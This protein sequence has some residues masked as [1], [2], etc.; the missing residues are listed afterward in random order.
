MNIFDYAMQIEK[1]AEGFADKTSNEGF[2]KIFTMLAEE[3][4]VHFR[5]VE[6]MKN[7]VPV[8]LSES[9]ILTDAKNIFSRISQKK[10]EFEIETDQVELYKKARGIEQASRDFYLEKAVE[11]D[12]A[13]QKEV[14][15]NLAD[16]EQKHY[17]LLDNIIELVVRPEQ[18]LED[19]EWHHLDE[20]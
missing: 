2:A 16:Q 19:S 8:E 11:V 18:W 13:F 7:E 20:Y 10:E 1:E 4:I 15:E 5:I 14:F 12:D 3:E 6:E 17:F 9:E